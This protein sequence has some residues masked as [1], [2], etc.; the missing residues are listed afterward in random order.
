[1][2]HVR[3]LWIPGDAG[4]LEAALRT[5]S[6]P[7]AVALICHPHPL[8]GGTLHNPVIFHTD[9]DLNGANLTTLRI[10]FRGTGS[11]QGIHDDGKGEL[12]D[13]AAGVSWLRG[14]A[15]D[16]PLLL[17][18]YS[19]GSMCCI[20]YA[21]GDPTIHG[22]VAI[23]L[24]V[25]KY[26]LESL[27]QLGCPLAVVQGS[28][29]EFGTPEQ[30]EQRVQTLRPRVPVETIDGAPHLFPGRPNEPAAAVKHAALRM[31]GLSSD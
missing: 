26:P 18:G 30:V 12:S 10:N 8:H 31:L 11:S 5:A 3:K 28:E 27:E 20:R 21:A 1:M 16:L 22:V 6:A 17:V 19:F 7:R 25:N 13:V 29:D 15:P 24:P 14:V 4:R 2:G 9:R 23:G